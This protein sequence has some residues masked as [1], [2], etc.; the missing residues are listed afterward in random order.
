MQLLPRSL[1]E[2]IGQLR[3][4]AR[5]V[6]RRAAGRRAPPFRSREVVEG[7]VPPRADAEAATRAATLLSPRTVRVA[8]VVHETPDAVTLVLE[9]PAGASLRF[10]P[11]QFFTL[12]VPVGEEI[13]R[14]A[15]SA[16]SDARDE[17]RAAVTVKRVAGGIVSNHLN[18]HLR[19]GDMLQILGPSGSFGVAPDA[20]V[21]RRL[22][23][24]AGGSGITP[25]MAIARTVLAV[26]PASRV[27]LIYGNRGEGD[28]IFRDALSALAREHAPRLVVRHVLHDPPAAWAG[29]AG[30]LDE[31]VVARELDASG[32]HDD[33][34]YLLCGPEPMM[35]AA[36]NTLRSRGVPEARI[37]EERFSMPHARPRRLPSDPAEASAGAQVLTLRAGGPPREVYVAPEQ[38]VLE[39]GLSA[40]IAMDYSCAMGG[41][42]ACKVRLV[43][44]EVDMEE[45][46][47]L[48]SQERAGGYV[49]A[50]IS[51]L[52]APASVVTAADAAFRSDASRAEAA[53]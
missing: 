13:L 33:A 48:T 31:T 7:G 47:C 50:C 43:D 51:R 35:T 12:L 29:S 27:T 18:D 4:D 40:G 20:K 22:V 45:P 25:M 24:V 3:L 53:E 39:A 19:P 2:V 34:D 30:L 1:R 52:R 28:I 36:R 6:A 37:L 5:Q 17:Q 32:P 44:G 23:L 49:L 41:C 38:T 10:A 14:R 11:G 46:N 8:D 16:C 15:Y 42:G 9:D 21:A 26:E